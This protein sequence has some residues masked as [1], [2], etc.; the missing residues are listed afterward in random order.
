M[1]IG[2]YEL[3]PTAKPF[4]IAECCNNFQDSM[5]IALQMI[6]IAASCG[7]DAVKFQHRRRLTLE[8]LALLA[9]AVRAYNLEFLCTAYDYEGIHE[10][11]PLVAAF[12]IGS[13][14]VESAKFV[15]AHCGTGKPLIIS[16]GG[17]SY[18]NVRTLSRSLWSVE[19]VDPFVGQEFALLQCTS[20]YP[21]P[22]RFTALGVMQRYISLTPY[23]GYSDHTGMVE[24][25]IAALTLGAKIIEV[26]F[27]LDRILPG[28]DQQVSHQ[29]EALL[30]ITRF[31][32]ALHQG[33]VLNNEKVFLDEEKVKLS[34]FRGK[35]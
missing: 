28:L 13:A 34:K 12:K 30:Q 26:H 22:P 21:T 32:E 6:R 11:A 10:I 17:M 2:N 27:T 5:E 29:P 31:A 25:P 33:G 35:V 1:K 18:Q 24:Y 23:V 8:H 14:E 19:D 9:E 16:T 3:T 7:A 20:I 4:I 15:Q